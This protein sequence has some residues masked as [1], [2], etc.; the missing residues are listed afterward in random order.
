MNSITV[1]K[2]TPYEQGVIQGKELSQIIKSN[3]ENVK[4]KLVADKVDMIRYNSFVESNAKFMEKNHRDLME[5]MRGIADGSGICM[6]D[7]LL[8]NIPAYFMTQY[9]NQE[10]SMVMVRG[11]ATYDGN[12][13]LI[14]NR[15]MGCMIEQ[16]VIKREN[17]NGNS[18]IEVSGAGVVTYPASGMNNY[19]LGVTTTGF[20][21]KS[22]EPILS[23]VDAAHIFVNIRLLLDN[24]KTAKE[25]IEYIKTSP[26]MN[27]L[28]IIAVDE[29]DA[30]AIETTRNSMYIE[31]D[32]GSGVLYRTNHYILPET[33]DLNPDPQQYQSTYKRF[34]RIG[35]MIKERYGKLRFQDLFRI[36]SDHENGINSICRHPKGDV[37]GQTVSSSM[38]ILEDREAWTT[39]GNPCMN[40]RYASLAE[41]R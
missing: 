37:L 8:L 2:G 34:E 15:D 17:N 12:T 36:M 19:G 5:E 29:K 24:C 27:G 18:M 25:V 39:I 28:N 32:D 16:A 23:E 13:Y 30:Y 38:V 1:V 20:W 10:C 26:R 31:E 35:E 33:K 14:K 22:A 3:I 11:K 21:S 40:L 6:E 7:I 9:L 41:K 4:T